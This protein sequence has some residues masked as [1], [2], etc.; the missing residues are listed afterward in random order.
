M[1][2]NDSEAMLN[3]GCLYLLTLKLMKL[4]PLEEVEKLIKNKMKELHELRKEPWI[5]PKDAYTA[6]MV[7]VDEIREELSSIPTIDPIAIIDEMIEE[8][9]TDNETLRFLYREKLKELKSRLYPLTQ[10]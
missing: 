6:M 5:L 2:M 4:I 3:S 1:I 7:W 9:D 8:K 10:K